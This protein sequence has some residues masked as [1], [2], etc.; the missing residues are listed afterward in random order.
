MSHNTRTRTR[1]DDS[2]PNR[3]RSPRGENQDGTIG[4]DDLKRIMAETMAAQLPR[5]IMEASKVVTEQLGA[6]RSDA[7]RSFTTFSHEM[8]QLK[9]K[10]EEIA[11]QT[12]ANGL[13]ADGSD[14][15]YTLIR[16][17]HFFP[18]ENAKKKKKEHR[19]NHTSFYRLQ[20]VL[21]LKKKKKILKIK[22]PFLFPLSSP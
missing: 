10:Q 18:A 21:S 17:N 22:I 3:D 16:S 20:A 13:K 15:I 2:D 19:Y 6:E 1:T 11:I 8:K 9:L 5:L 4:E 7:A 14:T 12:K